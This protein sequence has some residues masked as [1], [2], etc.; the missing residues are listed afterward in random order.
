MPWFCNVSNIKLWC[1]SFLKDIWSFLKSSKDFGTYIS[2]GGLPDGHGLWC[3]RGQDSHSSRAS[4]TCAFLSYDFLPV[5]SGK[6]DRIT[7]CDAGSVDHLLAELTK[8]QPGIS[9]EVQH[10]TIL[11][12]IVVSLALNQRLPSRWEFHAGTFKTRSLRVLQ[13]PQMQW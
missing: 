8:T 10:D 12:R 7:A 1:Y 4:Q 13:K 9:C 2:S 3:V 11:P 5:I 6:A